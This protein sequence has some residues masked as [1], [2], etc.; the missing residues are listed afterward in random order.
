MFQTT[1]Q[2]FKVCIKKVD[3]DPATKLNISIKNHLLKLKQF[4]WHV[5]NLGKKTRSTSI[6]MGP[7]PLIR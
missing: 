6:S 2:W 4:L 3:L 5:Q 1:N 7:L